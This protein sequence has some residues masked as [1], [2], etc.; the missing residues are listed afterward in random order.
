MRLLFRAQA[1]LN[2]NINIEKLTSLTLDGEKWAQIKG[3]PYLISNL[4]RVYGI[5]KGHIEKGYIIKTGY[6]YAE[7]YLN[8]KR[9]RF[10]VSHL[11][12]QAF[13]KGYEEGKHVHHINR[14]CSDDR[15][16]N[17]LPC[18]PAEHKAI[19]ALYKQLGENIE[20]LIELLT[21]LLEPIQKTINLMYS[22]MEVGDAA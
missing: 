22:G 4:G 14:K 5:E 18:T 1:L 7:L 19:H 21:P 20:L 13:C 2:M 17:L 12:A 10:K 3:Y 16:L 15:A 9:K 8:G 6:H 11:V